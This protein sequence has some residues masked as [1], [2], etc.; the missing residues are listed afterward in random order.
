MQPGA[1]RSGLSEQG[2]DPWQGVSHAE[3]IYQNRSDLAWQLSVNVT[4][5]YNVLRH[6][7]PL[8]ESSKVKK[9]VNISSAYGS[10]S[11]ARQWARVNLWL[12]SDMG[13]QDADLTVPEG[14][15]AVLKILIETDGKDDGSFKNVQV[16][17]W[18]GK[19]DGEN[20]SW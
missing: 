19:Y 8:M 11:L 10:I 12:K 1:E 3:R 7:I 2:L 18:E 20:L 6:C 4:G 15:E 9:V 5:T 17:G 14:A 13:G 16:A